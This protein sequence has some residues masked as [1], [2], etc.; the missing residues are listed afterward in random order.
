M[1][2]CYWISAAKV[3]KVSQFILKIGLRKGL[4]LHV[5]HGNA[6]LD[7][8]QHA[9]GGVLVAHPDGNAQE[10]RL[11]SGRLQLGKVGAGTGG[12]EG[13][14]VLAD[15]Q[16]GGNLPPGTLGS[17][18]EEQGKDG[19]KDLPQDGLVDQNL[20]D[21]RGEA[22]VATD[23]LLAHHGLVTH[24]QLAQESVNL[25]HA[26]RGFL[27]MQY[28]ADTPDGPNRTVLRP[29]QLVAERREV[30]IERARIVEE[31]LAP[32]LLNDV[33]A[34]A[35]NAL[36]PKQVDEQ[37]VLRVGKHHEFA[38]LQS[39]ARSRIDNQVGILDDVLHLIYILIIVLRRESEIEELLSARNA[40]IVVAERD[41]LVLVGLHL[42]A[43]PQSL[44]DGVVETR[45][46]VLVGVDALV[47]EFVLDGV[48]IAERTGRDVVSG[49]VQTRAWVHEFRAFLLG[50]LLENAFPA[51]VLRLAFASGKGKKNAA[52]SYG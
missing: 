23:V 33:I 11:L 21:K 42:Q 8:H 51:L 31:T 24:Q 6:E 50:V 14:G 15:R 49:A 25:D 5:F 13:E 27:A 18:P 22:K 29:A 17:V 26:G 45:G 40:V 43:A 28:E 48:E 47:V 32:N 1:I 3:R 39:L 36:M 30:D 10:G 20:V 44:Q 9:L 7:T 35:H 19:G 4:S 46:H 41:A 2:I 52:K 12:R 38:R 37:P 34:T 16:L